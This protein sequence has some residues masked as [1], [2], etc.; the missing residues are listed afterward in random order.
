MLSLPDRH[1]ISS[2]VFEQ[3]KPL[4]LSA[5]LKKERNEG[6]LRQAEAE[7]YIVSPNR[8]YLESRY[9]PVKGDSLANVQ[10][11]K[12]V[13]VHLRD[14]GQ[15]HLCE[16]LTI[17]SLANNYITSIDCLAYCKALVKLD[18]HS[19]QITTLP[20]PD[21]WHSL[22][23]LKVLYLHNNSISRLDCVH[24]IGAAQKLEL[25]TLYDT[26]I[27]L[28]KSYRHHVVNSIWSLR[29]L[30]Y[31][32]IS[33]EEIIEDAIFG[34]NFQT[35][36]VNFKYN[37]MLP[38]PTEPT[39]TDELNN[40]KQVLRH[41]SLIQAKYSPVLIIQKFIRGII[42]RRSFKKVSDNRVWG[43]VCIQRCWRKYKGLKWVAPPI[44]ITS[45]TK[46]RPTSTSKPPS[47][48]IEVTVPTNPPSE[49]TAPESLGIDYDTYLVNRRPGSIDSTLIPSGDDSSVSHR[50]GEVIQQELNV[51]ATV[52]PTHRKRKNIL[53]DLTKLQE[54]SQFT[55]DNPLDGIVMETNVPD[56][57]QI[58]ILSKLTLATD[59]TMIPRKLEKNK[60]TK[61]KVFKTVKQMLGPLSDTDLLRDRQLSPIFSDNE[62][63]EEPRIKFRLSGMK[64]AIVDV[65]KYQELLESR[66]EAGR[67]VR[68]ANKTFIENKCTTPKKKLR[69]KPMTADQRLFARVQGTMGMSCLRAVQQAYK[70]RTRMEKA[71]ARMDYV[72]GLREQR[73]EG[74][75][76]AKTILE[77]KRQQAIQKNDKDQADMA[78]QREQ[79]LLQ[80]KK[81]LKKRKAVLTRSQSFTHKL[82]SDRMFLVE[83]NGQHTSI[84]NAL[85]QHD[86]TAK[87]EED[88]QNVQDFTEAE[89]ERHRHQSELV[90]RYLEHRKLMRQAQVVV[91]KATLDTKMLQAANERLAEARN[92]VTYQNQRKK[93]V[94]TFYPLPKTATDPV[95]PPVR[96]EGKP[97]RWNTVIDMFD[98]H[99][100]T[101]PTT[102]HS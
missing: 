39:L 30:D 7:G 47:R 71:N 97:D 14:V 65:D 41:V 69:R 82:K 66:R 35:M 85:L 50:D 33:D 101:H 53:I 64:S 98:G 1:L 99:V 59:A 40:I 55:L 10:V 11:I 70:D 76:R 5:L 83:F 91:E 93:N 17:C 56:E 45:P 54:N 84:S 67:D 20:K 44:R 43:A 15:I 79:Q 19:N 63:D 49:A 58:E 75:L 100:G 88:L 61:R 96:Q 52:S 9:C 24:N 18:V 72:I 92:K 23:S 102:V 4:R 32:V 31:H 8:Q 38:L 2:W 60:D 13:G 68:E 36:H 81:A 27:S 77:E 25:L 74:K 94:Q 16:R 87:R 62:E 48:E 21:F 29:A 73:E 80:E 6:F 42:A 57:T 90:L 22:S 3:Q 78:K 46:Q 86:K 12:L 89:K 51:Q 95:L 26:P 37:P 28:K 34:G